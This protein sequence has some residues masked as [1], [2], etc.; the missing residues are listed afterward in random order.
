MNVWIDL[1]SS[2]THPQFML[3]KQILIVDCK[4]MHQLRVEG[5]KNILEEF[6]QRCGLF[7]T[8]FPAM[9]SG[10][11]NPL[12][13]ERIR[14][15]EKQGNLYNNIN[16]LIARKVSQ[17]K[18]I[19]LTLKWKFSIRKLKRCF[20]SSN[21]APIIWSPTGIPADPPSNPHGKTNAGR[22]AKFTLTCIT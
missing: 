1:I 4:F 2:R 16:I 17:E 9:T 15:H 8:I 11:Y 6:A 7:S 10:D 3:P 20:T 19:K 18:G 22:P 12:K 14:F 21:A 5:Q 13:L